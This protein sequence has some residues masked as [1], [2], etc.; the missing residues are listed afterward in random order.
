MAALSQMTM[1]GII[2]AQINEFAEVDPD[3]ANLLQDTLSSKEGR[4]RLNSMIADG[5]D[6]AAF[7]ITY[8]RTR[9]FK[10]ALE[11]MPVD[12]SREMQALRKRV[13]DNSIS[14]A[15]RTGHFNKAI[16]KEALQERIDAF[17]ALNTP[18]P[19]KTPWP[20]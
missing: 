18:A 8:L 10:K 1:A 2:Q 6:Y 4:Y 3:S 15:M 19:A 17:R 11:V 9:D 12:V 5:V 20:R 13:F 16:G 7:A 14:A